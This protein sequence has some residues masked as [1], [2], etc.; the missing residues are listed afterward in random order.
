MGN[1]RV[2]A[3]GEATSKT[4]FKVKQHLNFIRS[5]SIHIINK[6]IELIS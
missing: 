1:D 3:L 6:N 2:P 5:Q 4:T